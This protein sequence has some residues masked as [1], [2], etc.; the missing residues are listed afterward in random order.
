MKAI[1]K[2]LKGHQDQKNDWKSEISDLQPVKMSGFFP[3][4]YDRFLA[5]KKDRSGFRGHHDRIWL[6]LSPRI[7]A[8]GARGIVRLPRIRAVMNISYTGGQVHRRIRDNP[9]SFRRGR[10]NVGEARTWRN[11]A[12]TV[13][14][15][16]DR[17]PRSP[18]PLS[19]MGP[20]SIH[21]TLPPDADS[22]ADRGRWISSAH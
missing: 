5:A 10:A 3:T 15:P 22:L 1:T 21:L 16:T 19:P 8:P 6:K 17:P 13:S 20:S 14:H 7:C 9:T 18:R 12:A 2:G 11:R 4:R